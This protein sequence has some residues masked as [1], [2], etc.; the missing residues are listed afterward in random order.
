MILPVPDL[1]TDTSL[2]SNDKVE[3]FLKYFVD[4]PKRQLF[5]MYYDGKSM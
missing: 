3:Q 4:S 1:Y 2:L 5:Q